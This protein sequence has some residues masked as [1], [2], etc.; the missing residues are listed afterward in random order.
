MLLRRSFSGALF[1]IMLISLTCAG[2]SSCPAIYTLDG[3]NLLDN[4]GNA[5]VGVGDLDHD[6]NDDFIV[7]APFHDGNSGQLLD[8]FGRVYVVSGIDGSLL[9]TLTGDTESELFG[10]S[11][12]SASDI[13]GDGTNDFLVGAPGW[14]NGTDSLGRVYLFSGATFEEIRHF[15][16]QSADDFFG[17][18]VLGNLKLDSD[19]V[20]DIAVSA[21]GHDSGFAENGRV[22][23]YSGSDGHL[24]YIVD[25]QTDNENMGECLASPGD[26]NEDGYDDI[27]VGAP[28]Y[29]AET[30]RIYIISGFDGVTLRTVIGESIGNRFGNAVAGVNDV[31][32]DSLPDIMVGAPLYEAEASQA[33]KVYILDPL[34]GNSITV[35]DHVQSGELFGYSLI[36]FRDVTD[37]GRNEYLIGAPGPASGNGAGSVYLV[38]GSNLSVLDT[39]S[40]EESEDWFGFSLADAGFVDED[41]NPDF[42][43]GARWNDAAA[44]NAGRAYVFP[45]C[46]SPPSCAADLDGDGDTDQADLG[47]LLASFGFNAAGDIDGDGDT[48]QADLGILLADFGCIP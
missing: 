4:F 48:D 33:G 16:G 29:N 20:S 26:I 18:A 11:I 44:I 2:D 24:F 22:Y 14:N 23:T 43:V 34:T 37:D 27:V 10:F 35:I 39:Y 17:Y 28:A 36:M 25:G 42:L 45:V 31:N 5:V 7:S 40:G 47:I 3:E 21:I 8:D 30:G 13:D 41:E 6:G 9:T 19:Q 15:D 1:L 38:D 32:D 12:A 46:I